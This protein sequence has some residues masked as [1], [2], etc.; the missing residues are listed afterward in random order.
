MPG[1]PGTNIGLSRPGASVAEEFYPVSSRRK[2]K[3]V[4]QALFVISK[5]RFDET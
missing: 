3:S 4:F 5:R 2:I 1:I